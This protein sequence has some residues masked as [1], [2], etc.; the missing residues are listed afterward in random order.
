MVIYMISFR[1]NKQAAIFI[2][3]HCVCI[4]FVSQQRHT[5]SALEQEHTVHHVCLTRIWIL[6]AAHQNRQRMSPTP[7]HIWL[8]TWSSSSVT[9]CVSVTKAWCLK[10]CSHHIYP[11]CHYTECP[12]SAHWLRLAGRWGVSATEGFLHCEAKPT[13]IVNKGQPP[14]SLHYPYRAFPL[15]SL[16]HSHCCID[17]G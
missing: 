4:V 13:K 7:G 17:H 8:F 14:C 15:L 1:G 11:I 3:L 2:F 5:D 10:G 9:T 12:P 16:T 6:A